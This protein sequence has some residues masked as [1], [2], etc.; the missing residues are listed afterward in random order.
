MEMLK[1]RWRRPGRHRPVL[2]IAVVVA[3]VAASACLLLGV[4]L[5][6][7]KLD[8]GP[9]EAGLERRI[10]LPLSAQDKGAAWGSLAL[11]NGADSALTLDT[12]TF[13]PV[14]G[15]LTQLT[16]PYVWDE[17]RYQISGS[18]SLEAYQLPLPVAW[19]RVP[20]H[21][22]A[23]YVLKPASSAVGDAVPPEA[24]VVY[25]FGVPEKA[26]GFD[27]VTVGYHIGSVAYSK[28]FKIG[29]LLCPPSDQAP[30]D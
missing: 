4:R 7:H 10:T 1:K 9:L 16:T 8:E 24:E 20:K 28:T 13:G 30:C 12:V 18:G 15:G 23:G 14:A 17:S 25:E 5:T 26:A 22:L 29:F 11:T 6:V 3:A 2:I 21:P 19:A 27:E